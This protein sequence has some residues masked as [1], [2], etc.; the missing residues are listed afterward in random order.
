MIEFDNYRMSTKLHS[1]F[2]L[3]MVDNF[4]KYAAINGLILPYELFVAILL[5]SRV[6]SN[7]AYTTIPV[8][9]LHRPKYVNIKSDEIMRLWTI[10]KELN[11]DSLE[12]LKHKMKFVLKNPNSSFWWIIHYALNRLS[13]LSHDEVLKIISLYENDI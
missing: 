6:S 2:E 10:I 12:Q 3:I 7:I 8:F 9:S 5:S 11:I 1:N 13:S 4:P